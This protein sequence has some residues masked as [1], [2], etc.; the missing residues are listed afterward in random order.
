MYLIYEIS[1]AKTIPLF[2]KTCR[3]FVYAR[4]EKKTVM[5]RFV[6]RAGLEPDKQPLLDL[7]PSRITPT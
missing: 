2:K 5:K 3:T 7:G 4:Q 1:F 6:V